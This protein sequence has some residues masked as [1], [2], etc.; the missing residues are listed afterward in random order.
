MIDLEL[1]KTYAIDL[2]TQKTENGIGL[3]MLGEYT[4]TITNFI[5]FIDDIYKDRNENKPIQNKYIP[6]LSEYIREEDL[7]PLVMDYFTSCVAKCSDNAEKLGKITEII[8]VYIG[9]IT[10]TLEKEGECEA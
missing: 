1:L 8:T 7:K 3:E 10:E 9:Y 4:K 5:A 6:L 2:L